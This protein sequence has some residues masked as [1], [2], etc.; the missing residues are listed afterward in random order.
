[1]GTRLT[2]DQKSL[3][4]NPS[5]AALLFNMIFVTGGTGL[6]G[7]HLLFELAKR[8][9]RIRAL[10]RKTSNIQLVRKIFD[11]YSDNADELLSGIGWHEGDILNKGSLE[12][13]FK[14]V[15][16]VYHCAAVVSFDPNEDEYILKA[17]TGNTRNI[18]ELCLEHKVS[19]L[20]HLSS[21]AA[22]G[23]K[24]DSDEVFIDE[25]TPWEDS[26][27]ISAYVRSKYLS[28]QEVWKGIENGLNAVIVNPAIVLGPGDW[29]RSSSKLF[30]TVWKGLRF[31]TAGSNSFVDVRDVCKAMI[32]LMESNIS[33]ER[34]VIT[35]ENLP[36]RKLFNMVADHLSKKR[37]SIKTTK[38][39]GEIAWRVSKLISWITGKPPLITRS[40][41]IAGQKRIFFSNDKIRKQ[42]NFEFIPVEQSVKNTCRLL[43][44]ELG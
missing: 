5:G 17:N 39:M 6:I 8:G 34:F 21:V 1:M 3:G 31:Y 18:V 32:D 2:L 13:A 24:I 16:Q 35:S 30:Y 19:K 22:L 29:N 20:C 9:H 36:F 28:E 4:S 7:S 33:G 10:K 23:R 11:Y 37:P 26:E 14:D 44:K 25:N 12:K 15:H 41:T 27:N 40:T 38:L 43:L 42:L